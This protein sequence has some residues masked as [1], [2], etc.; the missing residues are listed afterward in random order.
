MA[1]PPAPPAPSSSTSR[2]SGPTLLPALAS[3]PPDAATQ[4]AADHFVTEGIKDPTAPVAEGMTRLLEKAT[5]PASAIAAL[6]DRLEQGTAAGRW[7][8]RARTR[9]VALWAQAAYRR[10]KRR[11]ARLP[12][13]DKTRPA[14]AAQCEQLNEAVALACGSVLKDTVRRIAVPMDHV[15]EAFDLESLLDLSWGDSGAWGVDTAKGLLKVV[16]ASIDALEAAIPGLDPPRRRALA[17]DAFVQAVSALDGEVGADDVAGWAPSRLAP[18]LRQITNDMC[19]HATPHSINL[20]Q[21]SLGRARLPLAPP[22]ARAQRSFV[23]LTEFLLH[24]AQYQ[25]AHPPPP[26]APAQQH[27]SFGAAVP[28]RSSA[29]LLGPRS[30]AL[31]RSQLQQTTTAAASSSSSSSSSSSASAA[32]TETGAA[33]ALVIDQAAID[34]SA[35]AESA[36]LAALVQDQQRLENERLERE[37][38]DAEAKA[39]RAADKAAKEASDAQ[40]KEDKAKERA[41][42]ALELEE[43]KERKKEEREAAQLKK[44][45]DKQDEDKARKAGRPP[46]APRR[47]SVAE[48]DEQ[49]R[50]LECTNG[51]LAAFIRSNGGA[52]GPRYLDAIGRLLVTGS[53]TEAPSLKLNKLRGRTFEDTIHSIATGTTRSPLGYTSP[54]TPMQTLV[55]HVDEAMAAIDEGDGDEG[56]AD[57]DGDEVR[58]ATPPR[59]PKRARRG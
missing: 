27:K 9:W 57:S 53:A 43:E 41:A 16:L 52:D 14:R 59:S 8:A 47:D 12:R 29:R 28:S 36:R 54:D 35:I 2:T 32:R 58:P 30:R 5:S 39:R 38:T 24:R 44:R 19:A 42:R 31:P 49:V 17:R 25:A 23:S 26:V 4:R 45:K 10:D 48:R 20:A 1:A 7:C 56:D 21:V 40:R 15:A 51:L 50:A 46:K 11:I 6:L 33:T 34:P 37:R 55:R 3:A 18:R 13:G 22:L